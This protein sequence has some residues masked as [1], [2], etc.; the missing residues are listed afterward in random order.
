MAEPAGPV[1]AG[2]PAGAATGGK[3]EE[4]QSTLGSMIQGISRMILMFYAMQWI[5]GMFTGNQPATAPQ[6]APQSPAYDP[7]TG[8]AV[9]R[10]VPASYAPLWTFS[11]W[12]TDLYVYLSED[13]YFDE[14]TDVN[15]LIWKETGMTFGNMS[16]VRV[17]DMQI[18]ISE[19]VQNN[20]SLYAHSFLTV[21]GLSPNPVA[22]TYDQDKTLYNRKLLTRYKKKKKVVIKKKLVAGSKEEEKEKVKESETEDDEE[23]TGETPIISY[24][25]QNLTLSVVPEFSMIPSNTPPAVLKTM[26]IHEDGLHYYPIFHADDFWLLSE[27]LMPINETTKTLNLTLSFRPKSFW[28]YTLLVQFEESFRVQN[29]MMGVEQKETDEIKRMFLETNPILLAVTMFVSLL[30]SVFD[31]LAFKNDIAFWKDKK[32]MDGMSFRT[33]VMNVAFQLIIFLY[34]FDNETS[35]M[36]IMSNA[37]GLVIEAWKIHKTVIVKRKDTF[38]FVEFI[39][40]FKP[41]KLA[42]KTQKYDE[43]AF[44]YLSYVFYPLLAGYTIYSLMYEEHKS[45]YSFIVGTLVGF[46]YMFGFI[47]MTPQ[48]FINYKLKSVAHMP[49]KTFMYKALNTFIDDLFA[50]VI[51]MPWLHRIACLRDDVIFLIYLYQRWIY[52]E[53]KRRRNEFGQVGEPGADDNQDDILDSDDEAE[54]KKNDDLKKD[55]KAVEG[56]ADVEEKVETKEEANADGEGLRKRK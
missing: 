25:W 20:G 23:D 39:D 8:R 19:N 3:P 46:V 22:K 31:F 35:W 44:R 15:K 47:S 41:S 55:I 34:L 9:P 24:W 18:E 2:G 12:K 51:K 49:W 1:A 26:R 6:K 29:E 50:F 21:R 37:V 27:Q 4:K 53:D 38:P 11:D 42:K 5:K 14:F 33:I 16:E 56:A 52:P 40:K 32:D 43:M 36:I 10:A 28:Y 7:T 17:K 45:W 13:E 30:H 48:L 54:A